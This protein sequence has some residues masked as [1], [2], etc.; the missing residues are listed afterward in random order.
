MWIKLISDC[1]IFINKYKPISV[2]MIGPPN[3]SEE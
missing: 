3:L 2:K 1:Y